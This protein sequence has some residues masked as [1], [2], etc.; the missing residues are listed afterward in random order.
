MGERRKEVEGR[1]SKKVRGREGGRE[2]DT[3]GR[4][5]K[6]SEEEEEE[7]REKGYMLE[8]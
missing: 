6:G 4:G 5:E 7:E 2:P 3:V 1:E 8:G